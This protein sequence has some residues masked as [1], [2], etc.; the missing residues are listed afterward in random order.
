MYLLPLSILTKTVNC[1]M[2]NFFAESFRW[3]WRKKLRKIRTV[4]YVIPTGLSIT[5]VI[6]ITNIFS[7]TGKVIEKYKNPVWM[8][9]W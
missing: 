8:R 7:L 6:L 5:F 4:N 3:F 9:Y 2:L 1:K